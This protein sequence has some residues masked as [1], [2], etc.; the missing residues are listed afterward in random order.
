MVSMRTLKD[1][2]IGNTVIGNIP[3]GFR[4]ES[5][6]N[7]YVYS[8]NKNIHIGINI[9]DSGDIQIFNPTGTSISGTVDLYCNI[10]YFTA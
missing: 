6:V 8:L 9:Y 10:A 5:V 4:P 7:E 3:V 1:I 2:P